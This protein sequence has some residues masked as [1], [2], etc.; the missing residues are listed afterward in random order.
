[1]ITVVILLPVL[2]A[3][4]A[5]AVNLAYIQ[6]VNTKLQIVTDAATRAA[7]GVYAETD[8][9]LLALAAAQNIANLNP[10]E[11]KTMSI[12]STDLEFGHAERSGSDEAFSFTPGANGNAVR[13]TT[14][15]FANGA[16][17]SV[18]PFFPMLGSNIDI[19]P[20][21]VA[22]HAQSTLDV[23]VVV[24]QSG[25]MA[26]AA[27]E[28]VSGNPAAAPENWAWGD[29]VPPNSR[30]LDLVAAVDAFCDQLDQTSKI[31]QV[32]LVGYDT[33]VKRHENL[34]DNYSKVADEL[35]SVTDQFHGGKTAVGDGILEAIEAVTDSHHARPWANNALIVMSDGDHNQGS[36]PVAAAQVAVSLEIPIYT[37]TFSAGADQTLMQQIEEMTGGSHYHATDALELNQVFREIARRLP[38]QL[39][40]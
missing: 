35:E 37:V 6:A 21:N 16:G 15:S 20:L 5:M 39:T 27:G 33:A 17:E 14:E 29:A 8:D 11:A 1:M 24:D 34:T 2:F 18:Q 31:E 23:C 10:V 36:D 40:Q 19:R 28:T 4:A 22:T 25:S 7:G 13:L 30:W 38:S 9:E 26:F 3:L 12:A 32:A